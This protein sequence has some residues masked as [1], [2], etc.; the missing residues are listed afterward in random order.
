LDTGIPRIPLPRQDAGE[1]PDYPDAH[2][3]QYGNSK[4]GTADPLTAVGRGRSFRL[5][6][7]PPLQGLKVKS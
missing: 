4:F 5:L 7:P 2:G 6:D 1:I 3:Q